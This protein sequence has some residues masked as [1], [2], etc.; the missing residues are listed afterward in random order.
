MGTLVFYSLVYQSSGVLGDTVNQ[1]GLPLSYTPHLFEPEKDTHSP[2]KT[3]LRPRHLARRVKH[4]PDFY[5][6]DQLPQL[7]SDTLV[8]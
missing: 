5:P 3:Q 4:G 1:A 2:T 6:E 8:Q 7:K